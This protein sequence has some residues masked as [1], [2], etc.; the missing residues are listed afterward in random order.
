MDRFKGQLLEGK[1]Y[2]P[3]FPYF[4]D[5]KSTLGAFR[6]LVATFVTTDQGTGVVHQAPYFG[7]VCCFIKC[8]FLMQ[9]NCHKQ[10]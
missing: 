3:L 6:V 7:E 5:R 4:A 10:F 2:Q 1:T 9:D 8:R